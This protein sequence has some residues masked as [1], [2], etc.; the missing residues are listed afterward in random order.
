[1]N[2]KGGNPLTDKQVAQALSHIRHSWGNNCS[3]IMDD[4]IKAY[5]AEIANLPSPIPVEQVEKIPADENLPPTKKPFAPAGAA[6]APA[7]G[8]A[9]APAAPAAVPAAK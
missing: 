3:I 2:A 5:N 6:P 1:M 4:Q 7:A 8:G 9:P